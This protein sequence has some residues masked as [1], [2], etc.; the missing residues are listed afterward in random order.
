MMAL[1]VGID[2]DLIPYNF[3]I[4]LS[5]RVYNIAVVY[6][7]TIDRFFVNLKLGDEIL[8]QGEKL[9]YGTVLFDQVSADSSGIL[10]PRFPLEGITP[11][12]LA[13]QETEVNF[14][15][16]NETVFLWIFE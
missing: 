3:D 2:K 13:K 16:L 6:N 9:T 10:D 5:E 8:I 4:T 11:Y 15:N 7:E 14:E 12:D 1:F